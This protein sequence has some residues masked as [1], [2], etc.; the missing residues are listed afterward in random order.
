MKAALRRLGRGLRPLHSDRSSRRPGLLVTLLVPTASGPVARV[1]DVDLPG[2]V[3]IVVALA[4]L[5]IVVGSLM[6]G[7]ESA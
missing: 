4:P 5:R 6:L 1:L 2:A 3:D 7:G